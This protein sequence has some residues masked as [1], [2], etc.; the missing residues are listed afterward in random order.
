[1]VRKESGWH[2]LKGP[3]MRQI[4][5][6]PRDAWIKLLM[7]GMTRKLSAHGLKADHTVPGLLKETCRK[8]W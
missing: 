1:M 4:D 8:T 6:L 7:D 5:N 2:T 3:T